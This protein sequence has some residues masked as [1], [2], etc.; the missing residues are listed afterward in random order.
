MFLKKKNIR[1]NIIANLNSFLL[2][3]GKSTA[4]VCSAFDCI[5]PHA[6]DVRATTLFSAT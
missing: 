2:C 4:P 3:I 6:I 1:V 5:T